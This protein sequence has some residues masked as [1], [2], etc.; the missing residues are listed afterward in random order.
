[1]KKQ[2]ILVIEDDLAISTLL[3][4]MLQRE[5]YEILIAA[6][7]RIGE[8]L[9]NSL[10][11]PPALVLLDLTLPYIDGMKLLQKIRAKHLWA[12]VP[13]MILTSSSLE[14]DI[15]RAFQQGASD[16]IVKPF[17][18]AEIM[19]RVERYTKQNLLKQ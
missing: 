2:L 7:G 19:A 10:L 17:F 14:C 13:V 6:D 9:L 4:F 1:M 5:G 3:E 16:Y 11:K 18:P 8:N 15:V 12:N